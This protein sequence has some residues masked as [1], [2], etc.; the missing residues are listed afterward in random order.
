MTMCFVLDMFFN[1]N[2]FL[3]QTLVI[4]IIYKL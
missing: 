1:N 4:Y 2:N 3:G